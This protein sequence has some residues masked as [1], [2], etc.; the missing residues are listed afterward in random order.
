M[1]E[2]L[3]TIGFA[4][5]PDGSMVYQN[6]NFAIQ[7][8]MVDHPNIDNQFFIRSVGGDEDWAIY[9]FK[10]IEKLDNFIKA[11]IEYFK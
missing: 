5:Y 3:K 8:S 1:K 2:E 10:S 4:N 6:E 9:P 11:N 7:V